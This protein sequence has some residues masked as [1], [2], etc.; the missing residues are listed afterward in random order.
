MKLFVSL[1]LILLPLSSIAESF[2]LAMNS[3]EGSL[4]R[5]SDISHITQ[6]RYIVGGVVGTLFGFGI[7]HAIQGR[8]L[9]RGWIF[10]AASAAPFIGT[11]VLVG[12]NF[13][14]IAS[15]RIGVSGIAVDSAGVGALVYAVA[16]IWGIVDV[17]LLPSHYKV[18]VNPQLYSYN[19]SLSIG[20]SLGYKW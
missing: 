1:F 3:T 11:I 14:M 6:S 20:L 7:G 13:H 4:T 19:D 5:N 15:G 17:W 12:T 2:D 8:W 10:T 18:T 16:T 9:E